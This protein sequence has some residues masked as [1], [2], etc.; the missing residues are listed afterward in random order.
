VELDVAD[1]ARPGSVRTTEDWFDASGHHS[2]GF[3][4]SN[5][6]PVE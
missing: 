5:L 2:R 4:C 1:D 6:A 3:R